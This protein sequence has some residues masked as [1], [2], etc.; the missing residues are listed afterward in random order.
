MK[1]SL[2]VSGMNFGTEFLTNLYKEVVKKGGKEED[3]F[4]ALKTGSN[5][6]PE[7]A[8]MVVET[9]NR[10]KRL[11]LEYLKLITGNI[12]VKTDSFSKDSFF[13]N[14]PM[15]LYFWESFKDQIFKV[16]PDSI[17]G[18]EGLL[19]KTQ[20][21]KSMF[22]SEILAELNN[23]QPFTVSEFAAIICELLSRQPNSEDGQ[24]LNNGYAN[25]FYVKLE[26]ER[27]VAVV[28]HWS[29]DARGW[30]LNACAFVDCKWDVGHCVFSRG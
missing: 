6:I 14:G 21:T 23:P 15:K 13:K 22:D 20:L 9:A 28:V 7:F 26:D 4:E 29:S 30:R 2:M 17:P 10:R 11:S 16:I 24:L 25:I 8:K 18:F 3:I 27:V 19:R 12:A 1:K 5:L